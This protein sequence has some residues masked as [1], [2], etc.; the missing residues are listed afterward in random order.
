MRPFIIDATISIWDAVKR[1]LLPTPAK[2]HYTF[3][4]RELARVFG[5]IFTV[6]NKPDYKVIAN[7]LNIKEK[8]RPELFLIS[9]WRHE[10]QR[11]FVDKLTNYADKKTFNDMLDR[12]TKEKFRDSLGFEDEQLMTDNLFCDFQR[13]DVIDEYGDIVEVA[14]FVYEACP[15]IEYIRNKCNTKLGGYNEKYP[16]KKMNL[17]IFDDALFHLLRVTRVINSPSGNVLL[18]GVGGSGK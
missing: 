3:T 1:R 11:T 5:G 8:I 15:D 14:P 17:V 10:C 9:L 12:V 7:C 13:E 16:S 6:A 18:V 4:L 2:F